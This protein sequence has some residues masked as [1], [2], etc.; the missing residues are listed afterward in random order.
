MHTQI[1][2][3]LPG[4]RAGAAAALGVCAVLLH[5]FLVWLYRYPE[6][7]QGPWALA[8]I[9]LVGLFW[10]SGGDL[11]SLGF[12]GPSGGWMKWVRWSVLLGAVI[13]VSLA[14]AA[15][16]WAVLGWRWPV[17]AT[18]PTQAGTAFLSM[19]VFA[20]L[21]EE[22]IYRVALCVSLVAAVGP[23]KAIVTSGLAFALLH[24][25]YGNPSPENL[26]G[27]FLLAWAY[28]R[29]ESVLIPVLL[30]AGGN[31][32]VLIWQIGAWYW[33]AGHG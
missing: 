20:P 13:A 19:C 23:W 28:I 24:V 1:G 26:L 14:A 30:H 22:S 10:L 12:Q 16:L 7:V 25:V 15:G 17:H 11:A 33:L 6:S 27:G 9:C 8:I 2:R 21:L 3:S 4:V 29:S 31:L 32:L 5:F 18:A